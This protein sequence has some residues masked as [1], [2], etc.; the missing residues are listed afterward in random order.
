VVLTP[1]TVGLTVTGYAPTVQ[2]SSGANL[3]PGAAS[4]AVATY[5][6]SLAQTANVL[7]TPGCGALSLSLYAPTITV[8]GSTTAAD[9]WNTL[10]S[11]GQTFEENI[12]ALLAL[13]NELH[14]IHGLTTGSPM[15]LTSASRSAGAILQA[16]SDNSSTATVARQ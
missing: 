15:V 7:V 1:A 14:L 4:L 3:I 10:M 11:N 9:I 16:I 8:S 5:A 13:A 12:L 2:V 6:P